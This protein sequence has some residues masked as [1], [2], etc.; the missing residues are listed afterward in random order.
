MNWVSREKYQV[1]EPY[2]QFPREEFLKVLADSIKKEEI[3]SLGTFFMISFL[4]NR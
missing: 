3:G 4:I 2:P 1:P